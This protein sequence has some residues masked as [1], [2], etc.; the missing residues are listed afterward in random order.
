MSAS[1]STRSRSCATRLA[2][3]QHHRGEHGTPRASAAETNIRQ[4][5]RVTTDSSRISEP[6]SRQ[7]PITVHASTAPPGH[8]ATVCR[9]CVVYV[10]KRVTARSHPAHP[11]QTGHLCATR[12]R[13]A[14]LAWPGRAATPQRRRARGPPRCRRYSNEVTHAAEQPALCGLPSRAELDGEGAAGGELRSVSGAFY[15]CLSAEWFRHCALSLRV[16]RLVGHN[17]A[18]RIR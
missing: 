4:R 13:T 2:D 5:R 12:R 17:H 1:P 3:R 9:P 16:A 18:V 11:G 10:V 7:R 8:S 14:T 15:C 6:R